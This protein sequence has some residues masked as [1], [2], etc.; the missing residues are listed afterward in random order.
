M[1]SETMLGIHMFGDVQAF[2]QE[3]AN[4]WHP[5]SNYDGY[6]NGVYIGNNFDDILLAETLLAES[7]GVY[8]FNRELTGTDAYADLITL[9][10]NH[11]GDWAYKVLDRYTVQALW[12]L[13]D[14]Y[15]AHNA[16]EFI[17]SQDDSAETL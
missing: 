11:Y 15:G 2:E 5:L 13:A 4:P 10:E 3:I 16:L 1:D 9:I 7:R 8:A 17:Q 12:S 6:V 14:E